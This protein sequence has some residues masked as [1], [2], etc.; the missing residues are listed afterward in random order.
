MEKPG[1]WFAIAKMWEKH[2]KRKEILRKGPNLYLEFHS[3]TAF[4]P[5]YANQPPWFLCKHKINSNG[6]FQ[7]IRVK[8]LMGYS[9]RLH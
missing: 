4:I 5:A 8:K 1:H 2:L 7:I 6:L 3:G 9:K